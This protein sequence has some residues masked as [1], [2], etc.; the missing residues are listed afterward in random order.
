MINFFFANKN[1]SFRESRLNKGLLA[2]LRNIRF[3]F[4][5]IL[6]FRNYYYIFFLFRVKEIKHVSIHPRYVLF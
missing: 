5:E 6:A 4:K 1:G 2:L 3:F